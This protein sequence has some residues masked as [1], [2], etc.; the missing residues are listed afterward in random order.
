MST[1]I[2]TGPEAF[3]QLTDEWD[4]LA[5]RGM[6]NTPFQTRAYQETWWRNLH[7]QDASLHIITVRQDN[8]DL[9]AIASLYVND[10]ILHFNGCVEETDYLDLIAAP[11]NAEVG[12][13]AVFETIN[14]PDFPEWHSAQF[15]NIPADSPSRRI[16]AK[17][18]SEN[19]LTCHEEIFE[20][21]PIISLP[22]SFDA[23]LAQIDSK[24]RREIK[25]KLRRANGADA[26]LVIIGPDDNLEQAVND[27][28]DLLQKSTFEKRDWLTEGRRAVFHETAQAAMQAGTLQLMFMEVNGTKAATLF[29]FDYDDRIWVY[30]S[31]LDPEAF[32]Q[33]SLGVVLTAKAIEWATENGRS[34]FDFLRGNETYKYR[35]GAKDT[36]IYR[37]TL[38]K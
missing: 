34:E 18:A 38:T 6:T 20:V 21:C 30:N 19:D 16:L 31:G 26:K 22:E 15:C 4:N 7:P 11:E 3:N 23:Y 24:Q 29:N 9:V 32:G 14:Q 17:L 12:W 13:T 37:I 36:E 27:F 28:L 25:R 1:K 8:N 35:F 2:I 33:L 10:G 5:A